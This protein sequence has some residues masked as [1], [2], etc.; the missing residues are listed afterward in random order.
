MVFSP[1]YFGTN[2]DII[3]VPFLFCNASAF[4]MV[5]QQKFYL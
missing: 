1:R 2:T 5:W 4:S 3:A